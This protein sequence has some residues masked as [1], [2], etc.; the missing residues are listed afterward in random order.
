MVEPGVLKQPKGRGKNPLN[1]PMGSEQP[2]T[3]KAR[4]LKTFLLRG[5]TPFTATFFLVPKIK[6][7]HPSNK[8]KPIFEGVPKG[9]K[10]PQ[11][12]TKG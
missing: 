4:N 11:Y 2:Q 10:L 5:C 1:L 7:N 12:R 6:L 9:L 3:H 8:P